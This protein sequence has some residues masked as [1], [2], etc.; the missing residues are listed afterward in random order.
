MPRIYI[1]DLMQSRIIDSDGETLIPVSP[2]VKVESQPVS[3]CTPVLK[4]RIFVFQRDKL[5]V[6]KY[7]EQSKR[8]WKIAQNGVIE[9][10][11]RKGRRTVRGGN[12]WM[13]L[14]WSGK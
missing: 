7:R 12:G 14:E 8:M 1:L 2:H 9:R 6:T 5:K 13:C 10:S 11:Q 3:Y 4:D